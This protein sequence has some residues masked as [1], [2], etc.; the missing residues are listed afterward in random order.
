M[1]WNPDATASFSDVLASITTVDL[2]DRVIELA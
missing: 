1:S 2:T